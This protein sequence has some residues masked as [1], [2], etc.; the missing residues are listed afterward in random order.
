MA[1]HNYLPLLRCCCCTSVVVSWLFVCLTKYN[2]P[3]FM[4]SRP[5]EDHLA[6][7]RRRSAS[8]YK[9]WTAPWTRMNSRSK[10]HDPLQQQQ[11]GAMKS[12]I[13]ERLK[14]EKASRCS[15][16]AT[17]PMKLEAK[18]KLPR[19]SRSIWEEMQ[20]S[21]VDMEWTGNLFRFVFRRWGGEGEE[22]RSTAIDGMKLQHLANVD[23]GLIIWRAKGQ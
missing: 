5:N 16:V 7:S 8:H 2:L 14:L 20:F 18:R 9:C 23:L 13:A 1:H 4:E 10:A 21:R 12:Q 19:V 17:V 3:I 15:L 22:K 6:Y 11:R